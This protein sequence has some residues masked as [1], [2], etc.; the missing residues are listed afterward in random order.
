MT[1]I[2]SQKDKQDF[3]VMKYQ[4]KM[5][6][7]IEKEMAKNGKEI[8]PYVNVHGK[9]LD[10]E[11]VAFFE[12]PRYSTGYTT[13]WG[14]VSFVAKVHMLKPFDDR[15]YATYMLMESIIKVMQEAK[16]DLK[17]RH[18]YTVKHELKQ[19]Y[20]PIRWELDKF[21][22]SNFNFKGYEYEYIESAIPGQKRLYCNHDKPFE[23]EVKYYYTYKITDSIDKPFAYVIPQG[24]YKVVERL[25]ANDCM[26]KQALSDTTIEVDYYDITNF[27]SSNRPYEGHF[28]HNSITTENR[29]EKLYVRRGDYFVILPN[30]FAIETL[31]PGAMDAFL[32][33][34]FFDPVLQQKEGFSAYVF[35]R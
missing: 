19:E 2:S 25:E 9:A 7:L 28:S 16:E 32:V 8:C 6:P 4:E 13:L 23:K 3:G 5:L 26:V 11:I 31:E 21:Q 33:W 35:L 27:K 18:F 22:Y 29:T 14:T 24:W 10:D 15:V 17:K 20:W 1:L 30:R 34:N 12:S